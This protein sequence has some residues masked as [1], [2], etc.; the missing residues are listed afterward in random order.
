MDALQTIFD[1]IDEKYLDL[2]ALIGAEVEE[3]SND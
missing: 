1:I 3:D 2:C